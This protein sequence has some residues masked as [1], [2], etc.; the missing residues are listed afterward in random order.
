[1]IPEHR[2]SPLSLLLTD[3]RRRLLAILLL[4]PDESQHVR[5]LA[6]LT[7]IP[8]GSLHR[9][10]RLLA[11]AGLLLREP[12]GNQVRYRADRQCPIFPELAAIFRKT[13]GL[14]DRVREALQPLG[15][16]T[17]RA[18]VFGSMAND[19]GTNNSD[20]DVMVV[21][22]A[23]FAEVVAVLSPLKVALGREVNPVVMTLAAYRAG[24]A[25]KDRFLAR[26][27]AEPKL[28]VIGSDD[29]PGQPPADR[30]TQAP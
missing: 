18:F 29:D 17:D 15:S 28:W 22:E 5:E 26:I 27:A 7:G 6:R 12:L 14:A 21:G 19:G 16:K 4:K 9:E 23:D 13:I 2:V 1:M 3:Y 25:A 8:P 30:A 20:V 10:L 24:L 11:D